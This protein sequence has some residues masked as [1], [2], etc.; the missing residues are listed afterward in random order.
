MTNEI[1]ELIFFIMYRRFR[2]RLICKR[3]KHIL[4]MA[5]LIFEHR[6]ED[7]F[8][9]LIHEKTNAYN[10]KGH[11]KYVVGHSSQVSILKLTFGWM[12]MPKKAYFS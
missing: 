10:Y 3:F 4:I 9:P 6:P 5:N 1:V 12:F 2:L 11:I 7:S 8:F